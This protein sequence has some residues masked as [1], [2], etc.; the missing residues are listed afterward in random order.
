MRN[1]MV[2]SAAY[3]VAKYPASRLR[4]SATPA[5]TAWPGLVSASR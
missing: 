5:S 4:L 2:G 3:P 1:K